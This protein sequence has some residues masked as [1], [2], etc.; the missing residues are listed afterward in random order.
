[1]NVK[2]A[3][4]DNSKNVEKLRKLKKIR[5]IFGFLVASSGLAT[6]N[7]KFDICAKKLP[8]INCNILH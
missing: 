4:Q 7:A 1:M 6:Q 2:V 5:K 3:K 8:I